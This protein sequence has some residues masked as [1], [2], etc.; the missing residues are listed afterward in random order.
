MKV[1]ADAPDMTRR[2]HH[3]Y[4]L[5]T[6]GIDRDLAI[7]QL[8]AEGIPAIAGWYR[9]LYQ[10]VVFQTAHEG[11]THGITSPLADKGVDYRNVA[12]PVCE[13]VCED[14]IWIQQNVL[15]GS[16]QQTEALCEGLQKVFAAQ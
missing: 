11:P 8:E 13:A 16:E 7:Q 4:I 15:L 1:L 9:P 12:C 5:R 6:N 3:M 14:A 10:N 2:S